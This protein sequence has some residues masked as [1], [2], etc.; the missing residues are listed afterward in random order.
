[1]LSCIQLHPT[2]ILLSFHLSSST[3]KENTLRNKE[4]FHRKYQLLS[5]YIVYFDYFLYFFR[6]CILAHRFVLISI[7]FL[8]T[9]RKSFLRDK[10]YLLWLYGFMYIYLHLLQLLRPYK[11]TVQRSCALTSR[12]RRYLL[13]DCIMTI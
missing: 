12:T 5:C 7:T 11:V 10:H 8:M 1:M 6:F 9:L 2:H 13:L 4:Y 3:P